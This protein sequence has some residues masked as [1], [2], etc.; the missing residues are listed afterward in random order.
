MG[1]VRVGVAI[2]DQSGLIATPLSTLNRSADIGS[3]IEALLMEVSDYTLVEA[4]IGLPLNLA[5]KATP[6][7]EDALLFAESLEAVA[8]FPIRLIDERL[9][10]VTASRNLRDAGRNAKT[11]RSVIDQEA[12][13]LILEQALS[14][15]RVS[16]RQPGKSIAE[17]RDEA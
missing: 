7:T 6:S 16:G 2:S 12:A 5:G 3:T 10:T 4:F 15:E 17:V 8:T 11:S 9:T 13:T 14:M 1:K